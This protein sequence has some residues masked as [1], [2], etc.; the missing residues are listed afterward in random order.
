M[1]KAHIKEQTR[2]YDKQEIKILYSNAN[3]LKSKIDSL[4]SIIEDLDPTIICITEPKFK[5]PLSLKLRS[6]YTF[7]YKCN[8][9]EEFS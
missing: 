9:T 4:C 1:E 2:R 3:G 7:F 6:A 8:S 5:G